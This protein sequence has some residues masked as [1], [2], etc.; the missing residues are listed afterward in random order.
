MKNEKILKNEKNEEK[1]KNGKFFL[2]KKMK[3]WRKMKNE[4]KREPLIPIRNCG[5]YGIQKMVDGTFCNPV[6]VDCWK[7]LLMR[8]SRGC[9]SE[10]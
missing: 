6:I 7:N 4:K 9:W 2:K 5:G 3:K 1:S 10:F 8:M